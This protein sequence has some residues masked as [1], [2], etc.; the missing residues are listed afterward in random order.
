M[1][2]SGV[3]KLASAALIGAIRCYQYVISPLLGANCRFRPTCSQYWILSVEKHGFL[4][5]C[6]HGICRIARCHPWNPGGHDP[7]V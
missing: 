3:G 6:W 1:I 4:R 5:G 2:V 7:P